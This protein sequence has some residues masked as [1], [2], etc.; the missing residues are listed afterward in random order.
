MKKLIGIRMAPLYIYT[1]T[2]I[3][4]KNS[5]QSNIIAVDTDSFCAKEVCT[6]NSLTLYNKT[7]T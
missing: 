7:R 2:R 3:I 4:I 1:L 6:F 5:A